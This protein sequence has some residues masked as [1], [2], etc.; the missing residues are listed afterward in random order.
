M[1]LGDLPAAVDQQLRRTAL[2][3]RKLGDPLLGERVVEPVYIDVSFHFAR[4][5]CGK[6]T[7]FCNFAARQGNR[8]RKTSMKTDFL[9][10]GSGAAGL[11]FALKAAAHGHVTIVTKGR[12]ERVQHQLRPGRHLFGHL[13]SRHI[14]KTHPRHAR[15]R[16]RQV[17]P[18][19]GRTSSC[20]GLRAD[21]R[22]DRLGYAFR[23]DP[24]TG[25][26]SSTARAATRS[27]ASSTTRT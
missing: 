21:P 15:L 23:Q 24:P 17:R 13:R 20:G 26:S 22:P 5:L 3:Q 19:S 6:V 9:V 10:I 4:I 12:N 16:G 11:S 2:S 25:G 1:P 8:K 14:R 7:I 18:R 27:T